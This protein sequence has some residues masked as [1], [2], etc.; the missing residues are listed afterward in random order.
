MAC[1]PSLGS[2]RAPWKCPENKNPQ[3]RI[4]AEKAVEVTAKL[5]LGGWRWSAEATG[6]PVAMRSVWLGEHELKAGA[7]RVAAVQSP[8]GVVWEAVP[9]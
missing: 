6:G 1:R 3:E 9:P 7:C 5:G 8:V 2:Q 4:T